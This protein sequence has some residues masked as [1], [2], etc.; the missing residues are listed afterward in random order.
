MQQH[1]ATARRAEAHPAACE[2]IRA[3]VH[4]DV[5]A[6]Q[7]GVDIGQNGIGNVRGAFIIGAL[8]DLQAVPVAIEAE[9]RKAQANALV[10][11]QEGEALDIGAVREV[12]G[13]GLLA[14]GGQLELHGEGRLAVGGGGDLVVRGQAGIGDGHF[15]GRQV[16]VGVGGEVLAV[17]DRNG[18]NHGSGID[19]VGLGLAR[20]VVDGRGVGVD[21]VLAGAD[22]GLRALAALDGEV[23]AGLDG[24]CDIG[25]A[26]ALAADRVIGAVRLNGRNS[27][28]HEQA[29]DKVAQIFARDVRIILVQVLTQQGRFAD[30]VRRRHGGAGVDLIGIVRAEDGGTDAAAGGGNFGLDA[31]IRSRALAGERAD[32]AANGVVH[33][34]V[35]L[36]G[37]GDLLLGS[38]SQ[39]FAGSPRNGDGRD[40]IRLQSGV[41]QGAADV[42]VDNA[43]D[44]TGLGGVLRLRAEVQGAALHD[45]DL[46]GQVETLKVLLLAEAGDHNVLKRLAVH[47]LEDIIGVGGC[48]I[49]RIVIRDLFLAQHQI[50]RGKLHV[51]HRGDR[52]AGRDRGGRRNDAVIRILGI[53]QVAV[54]R[55]IHRRGCLVACCDQDVDAG[56]LGTGIN[57]V[58]RQV[59]FLALVFIAIIRK[60]G[61]R[62]E[63]H[64]DGV[65]A[66]LD[67]IVNAREDDIVGGGAGVV[68]E[69]L[70]DHQLGVRGHAVEVLAV[71]A[72]DG[73]CNV[74]A[75]RLA[76]GLGIG[77]A[78]RVVIAVGGL[79]VDVHGIGIRHLACKRLALQQGGDVVLGILRIRRHDGEGLVRLHEAGVEDGDDGAGAVIAHGVGLGRADHAGGAAHGDR[80][81]SGTEIL[82]QAVLLR[83]PDVLDA[84]QRAD[85]VKLAVGELHG[86]AVQDG[87]I[88]IGEVA[89][90]IDGS[91]LGLSGQCLDLGTDGSLLVQEVLLELQTGGR[92]DKRVEFSH[93]CVCQRLALQLHDHRNDVGG[94]ESVFVVR[95]INSVRRR[96][97]TLD[98]MRGDLLIRGG[99]GI[100]IGP[101][102]GDRIVAL[103][104]RGFDGHGRNNAERCQAHCQNQQD[105]QK[106]FHFHGPSSF[107]FDR[108]Q[109]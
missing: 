64:V 104:G 91:G 39:L 43:R 100:L 54:G 2:G 45:R 90:A 66:E 37:E 9:D 60:A 62:A 26:C 15:I 33:K 49:H 92:A 10:G 4:A 18:L 29:V 30:H 8:E 38:R 36:L 98:L 101:A 93:G 20:H 23:R 106:P 5:V 32:A 34:A 79:F 52:Q 56:L 94:L 19:G 65:R 68:A 3:V 87:R 97:L 88:G 17:D 6:A 35:V 103:F 44:C 47:G 48:V 72:R 46:A 14:G 50:G 107:H 76:N 13:I 57:A 105:R 12:A 69:D 31:Q 78:V 77:V 28:A 1:T 42:V 51:I 24:V 84:V 89:C 108:W 73:A 67:G 85:L 75:V 21:A 63:G 80:V 11:G 96:D 86:E 16:A 7:G 81:V 102:G 83:D 71:V 95:E 25:N 53:R 55:H 22:L 74:D 82:G 27:G 70:H 59:L 41:Q 61:G 40:E 58:V 99:Q 109:C